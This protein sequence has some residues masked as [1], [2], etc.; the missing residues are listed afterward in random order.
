MA[1]QRYWIFDIAGGGRRR[2]QISCQDEDWIYGQHV[3]D[4]AKAN[5]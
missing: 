4:C 2:W 3:C 5:P 1:S